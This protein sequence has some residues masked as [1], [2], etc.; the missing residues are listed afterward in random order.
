MVGSGM[1][2]RGGR[3]GLGVGLGGCSLLCFHREERT[4]VS[5]RY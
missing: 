3:V 2:G 4:V 1:G 5:G